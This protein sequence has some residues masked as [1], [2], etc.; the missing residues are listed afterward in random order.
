M[1]KLL[2]GATKEQ[3]EAIKHD[4]GPAF[5]SAC[6]GAGKCVSGGTLIL[7]NKG[8]I[9]IADI[10]KHFAVDPV[11]NECTVEVVG[12]NEDKTGLHSTETSHWFEFPPTETIEVTTELGNKIVG[13]P[14]HRLLA[15]YPK[16]STDGSSYQHDYWDKKFIRLDQ[17]KPGTFVF[18]LLPNHAGVPFIEATVRIVSVESAGKRKVYDFTVPDGHSFVG[19]GFVNHNTRVITHRCAYLLEKGV[20]PRNIVGITFT[21][22]AANEMKSRIRDMVNPALSKKLWLSTFHSFCARLLRSSPKTYQVHPAF[23]IA[24]ESDAKEHVVLA[25]AQILGKSEKD[26]RSMDRSGDAIDINHVRRWISRHKNATHTAADVQKVQKQLQYPDYVPYYIAY[27]RLLKKNCL[28]DFDDLLLYVVLGL[29][30]DE[31]IRKFYSDNLHYL[32]VDEWQDTN[33]AQFEIVRRMC[34]D[35]HN[36]FVVGDLEQSVY[37]FR[38]ANPENTNRFYESFPETKT[39]LLTKNFRSLPGIAAVANTVIAKNERKHAKDI[40]T[41]KQGGTK[42][43]CVSFQSPDDEAQYIASTIVG[44]VKQKKY[45]WQDFAIIYRIRSLS[46]AVEDALVYQNVPYRVIGANTF[47]NRA[48]IKDLLAYL[49]LVVH[50]HDNAAYTRIHNKPTRGIGAV[51]F[52]RF[53]SAADAEGLSLL[54]AHL[55]GKYKDTVQPSALHGFRAL[56]KLFSVARK[57]DHD[58]VA[59][60]MRYIIKQSNYMGYVDKIRDP[61]RR[62]KVSEDIHELVNAT[63]SFDDKSKKKGIT[64]YLDHVMLMQQDT[65]D[66]EDNVATLMTAHASKG[67]EFK[68]VF[69]IGCADGVLPLPPRDEA[70]GP[71]TDVPSLK[72]HYEEERRVFYVAVTRAEEN[73]WITWPEQ[74]IFNN[75]VGQQNPSQFITEADSTLEHVQLGGGYTPNYRKRKYEKP[76]P[77][78]KSKAPRKSDVKGTSRSTT[79]VKDGGVKD[80]IE[81]KR[82]QN[83]EAWEMELRRRRA[84]AGETDDG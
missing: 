32:M 5:V 48:A 84:I 40:V 35:H 28:L 6:P 29:R 25:I 79:Q 34:E 52:Q 38:G 36:L 21:N 17:A 70:G 63:Q 56:K 19:N 49:R 39:Y 71:L 13:T 20:Q 12:A 67:T 80:V 42:P 18:L 31:R 82:A 9:P 27:E 7:T 81:M 15:I 11:T 72:A 64:A 53:A 41:H 69:L 3:V 73:L 14:E 58:K 62:G 83:G 44:M 33:T 57:M 47:Y 66:R 59:P 60:V 76:Q 24:D 55:K 2:A 4:K 65:K 46:R 74:R 26:V 10:P 1:S 78:R 37:A 43:K 77:T 30:K 23:G 51:N 16:I 45:R 61:E 50:P 68:N 22:K 8:E 75:N 54:Q